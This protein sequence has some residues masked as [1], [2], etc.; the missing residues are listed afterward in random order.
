MYAEAGERHNAPHFHARYGEHR[1]TFSIASGDLMSGSLPKAQLR[2][3]QAWAELRRAELETDWQMLLAGRLLN[4]IT[5]L[6]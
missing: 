2:L 4:K 6:S 5:P 3:I 1:A